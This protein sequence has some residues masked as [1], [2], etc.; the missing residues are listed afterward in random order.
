MEIVVVPVLER[1][2]LGS[3]RLLDAAHREF[4]H[5]KVR[6]DSDGFWFL[7]EHDLRLVKGERADVHHYV[8]FVEGDVLQ[9]HHTHEVP[10]EVFAV[11]DGPVVEDLDAH[12]VGGPGLR[13]VAEADLGEPHL[14]VEDDNVCSIVVGER[15]CA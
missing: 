3:L 4:G 2:V 8:L 6:G 1:I 9:V 7:E 13:V 15:V 14:G 10:D 11:E 5:V 12:V